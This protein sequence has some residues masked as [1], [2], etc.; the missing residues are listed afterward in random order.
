ML[1]PQTYWS[2]WILATANLALWTT[3][4]T[5]T[6]F[7]KFWPICSFNPSNA[8]SDSLTVTN[9]TLQL[10]YFRGIISLIPQSILI[11]NIIENKKNT[12]FSLLCF[13]KALYFGYL[14]IQCRVQLLDEQC[15]GILR[16]SFVR[17]RT[18]S[19]GL[20]H[21]PW[22]SCTITRWDGAKEKF[23]DNHLKIK[24]WN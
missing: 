15:V 23:K 8:V 1:R 3:Y 19:E 9:S 16:W 10:F 18:R 2:C 24:I 17:Q 5:S 14:W 4:G 12:E 6:C 20:H 21:H 7:K 13:L 11:H 22:C